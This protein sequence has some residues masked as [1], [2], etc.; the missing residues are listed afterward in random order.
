[1]NF[2]N[3]NEIWIKLFN[4]TSSKKGK[5]TAVCTSPDYIGHL[6][7]APAMSQ[8]QTHSF[9]RTLTFHNSN[10][11]LRIKCSTC[12]KIFDI[13]VGLNIGLISVGLANAPQGLVRKGV[14]TLDLY[15]ESLMF[16]FIREW[17]DVPMSCNY[18]PAALECFSKTV[19]H[20]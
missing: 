12:M 4:I 20:S 1:M 6:I 17:G 14:I 5:W 11:I 3:S 16:N 19:F 7:S 8:N 15:W 13:W 9:S 2:S 18:I 10:N